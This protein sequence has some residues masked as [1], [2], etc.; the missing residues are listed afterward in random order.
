MRVKIIKQGYKVFLRGKTMSIIIL[1]LDYS[2]MTCAK[3]T[4]LKKQITPHL[5]WCICP[6]FLVFE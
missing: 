4:V 1:F 2:E 6:V 3:S 5:F